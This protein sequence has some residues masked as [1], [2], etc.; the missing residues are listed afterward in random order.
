MGIKMKK[1]ILILVFVLTT[2][3]LFVVENADAATIWRDST[4]SKNSSW[5]IAG[6]GLGNINFSI[7][8]REDYNYTYRYELSYH[9]AWAT[10]Y[11]PYPYSVE[12]QHANRYY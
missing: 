12:L 10:Y 1:F 8:F 6:S 3:F 7:D 5:W 9:Q 2:P 4:P 11:N